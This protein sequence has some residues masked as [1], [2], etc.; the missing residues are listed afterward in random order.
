MIL[1]FLSFQRDHNT[2]IRLIE[3]NIYIYVYTHFYELI[4][5]NVSV[6]GQ[7]EHH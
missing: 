6:L 2:N 1:N 7:A 5:K 3:T 4:T